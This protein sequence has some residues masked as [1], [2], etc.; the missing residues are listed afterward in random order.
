MHV[1]SLISKVCTTLLPKVALH[2]DALDALLALAH[3][4]SL[5]AKACVVLL[6]RATE[7]HVGL[8]RATGGQ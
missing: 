2:V 7:P 8:L 1:A 6:I 4:V 3:V 5:I